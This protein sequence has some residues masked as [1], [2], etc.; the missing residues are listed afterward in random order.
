MEFDEAT[1]S[2]RIPEGLE[3]R[4]CTE[5]GRECVAIAY[6][7]M[8]GENDVPDTCLDDSYRCD[9]CWMEYNEGCERC[10]GFPE[11][12]DCRR[13]STWIQI[14]WFTIGNIQRGDIYD[15][16]DVSGQ[17]LE[18]DESEEE[19]SEEETGDG[20]TETLEELENDESGNNEEISDEE[21]KT[22]EDCERGNEVE[23]SDKEA[24]ED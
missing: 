17:T 18:E 23:K 10:D 4:E 14:R 16:E 24:L 13:I 15:S 2:N 22:L 12:E 1:S 6:R 9:D 7:V 19:K 5:C 3:R 21:M 8:N 11:C 20:E